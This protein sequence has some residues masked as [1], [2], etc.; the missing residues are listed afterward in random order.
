VATTF[1]SLT[2]SS[3]ATNNSIVLTWNSLTGASYHLQYKDFVQPYWSNL[4]SLTATGTVTSWTD[5]SLSSRAGR[6]YRVTSP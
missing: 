6:L 4:T 2:I 3:H 5:A 1:P